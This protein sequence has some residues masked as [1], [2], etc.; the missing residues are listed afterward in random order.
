MKTL[1]IVRIPKVSKLY[2]S[3]CRTFL[4]GPNYQ[5]ENKLMVARG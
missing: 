5:S 1:F 2:N 3:I 4:R